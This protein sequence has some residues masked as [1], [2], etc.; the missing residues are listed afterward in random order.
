MLNGYLTRR[1]A[2]ALPTLLAVLPVLLAA[3]FLTFSHPEVEAQSAPARPASV[4]VT[5]SGNTLNIT[6]D[7][8]TGATKYHVTYSSDNGNSWTAFSDNATGSSISVG[9]QDTTKTYV[10]AVRAGNQYG[11]SGWRNS[12]PIAPDGSTAPPAAPSTININLGDGTLTASW[13]APDTASKYHVTYSS[14]NGGSWSAAPCGDNCSNPVT[15]NNLDNSKTYVVAVRAGNDSGWSGW[16][17]SAASGPYDPQPPATP[18][19]FTVTRAD[20]T[21][22]ATWNAVAGAHKYHINYSSDN[23]NSWQS[24]DDDYNLLTIT[25]Y[26]DNSKTYYVA[27]R[28]GKVISNG[29]L[30]SGWRISEASGP[31]GPQPPATPS[32]VTVSRANG[33]LTASGYGVSGATKYHITYSADGGNN[34]SA[35]PCGNNCTGTSITI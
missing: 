9:S 19:P 7:T 25:R 2:V 15:I 13:A 5:R 4:T 16:S 17:H 21:L 30:W 1:R 31:Y 14:N 12:P 27:I 24:F 22:T 33:T 10:V 26:A 8:P 28:A 35:A 23:K 6:W 18:G 20:G 3:V 29:I 32:T 34:W 11:W